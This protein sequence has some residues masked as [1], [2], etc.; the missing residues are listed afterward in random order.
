MEELFLLIHLSPVHSFGTEKT[1]SATGSRSSGKTPTFFLLF[2][3]FI[4]RLPDNLGKLAFFL[5]VHFSLCLISFVF[6][7]YCKT[8]L[9][10]AIVRILELAP[11]FIAIVRILELAPEISLPTFSGEH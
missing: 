8:S 9:F 11:L 6:V 4:F 5:S 10:I 2:L 1:L 3:R 7:Y